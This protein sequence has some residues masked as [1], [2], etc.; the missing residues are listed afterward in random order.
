[1]QT[2]SVPG[3]GPLFGNAV[4]QPLGTRPAYTGKAPPINRKVACYKNAKPN[5][6]KV[7]TGAGP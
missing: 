1:M 7:S 3:I 4:L 6:N 5:L 2:S